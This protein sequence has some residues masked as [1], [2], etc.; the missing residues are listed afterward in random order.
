MRPLS[1]SMRRFLP[2]VRRVLA[3]AQQE[4]DMAQ[5]TAVARAV[6][7]RPSSR[8]VL[9]ARAFELLADARGHAP[10]LLEQQDLHRRCAE[11]WRSHTE[12]DAAS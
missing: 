7:E 10:S 11:A 9:F 1:A 2:R 6:S 5:T 12:R 3:A 4:T 8:R